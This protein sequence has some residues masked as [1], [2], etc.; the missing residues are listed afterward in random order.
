MSFHHSD[1]AAKANTNVR[2]FTYQS[3]APRNVQ[4]YHQY[5][6]DFLRGYGQ[7]TTNH[8]ATPGDIVNKLKPFTC[9]WLCRPSVAA[10]ETM[11]TLDANWDCLEDIQQFHT[12]KEHL[13]SLKTKIQH[14]SKSN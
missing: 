6:R 5:P 1:S 14:L 8:V 2:N 11:A 9:E 13:D 10:S 3:K 7:A 4:F 12:T